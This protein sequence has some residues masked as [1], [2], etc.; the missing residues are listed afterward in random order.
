LIYQATVPVGGSLE[1]IQGNRVI[2]QTSDLLAVTSSAA[3]SADC[4][5]SALTV[6]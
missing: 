1:V 3:T 4:W 6:I 5:V 2:L